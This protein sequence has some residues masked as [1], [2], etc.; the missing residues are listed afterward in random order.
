MQSKPT[1][2]EDYFLLHPLHFHSHQERWQRNQDHNGR[3]NWRK[4]SPIP[5]PRCCCFLLIPM[6]M[7]SWG[8]IESEQLLNCQQF[9]NEA[10]WWW[11]WG[12]WRREEWRWWCFLMLI[13]WYRW[14]RVVR[15]GRDGCG[16]C[17]RKRR[18]SNWRGWGRV[19]MFLGGCW[20]RFLH[21]KGMIPPQRID[22][23]PAMT[24]KELEWVCAY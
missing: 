11:F 10:C 23:L 5:N 9:P 6:V 8:R 22:I 13:D 2:E 12:C 15:W 14:L 17:L 16:G 3:K 21:S 20:M 4:E 7:K 18:N 19:S 1:E 24:K